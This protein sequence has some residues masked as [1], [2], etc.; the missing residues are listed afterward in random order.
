M[1][2]P[3]F[4]PA[5]KKKDN[6]VW[7]NSDGKQTRSYPA[8]PGATPLPKIFVL[9]RFKNQPSTALAS[10]DTPQLDIS[11]VDNPPPDTGSRRSRRLIQEPSF[12]TPPLQSS[13]K[14]GHNSLGSQKRKHSV[15]RNQ[16]HA[17]ASI[18]PP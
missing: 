14:G 1:S 16:L 11:I 2:N 8:R 10:V 6:I 7:L 13:S 4:S 5:K 3:H 9:N 18:Q 15:S 17:A 12:G